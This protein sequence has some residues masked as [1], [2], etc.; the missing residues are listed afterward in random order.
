MTRP[1]IIAI[2]PDTRGWIII[3][4]RLG[5]THAGPLAEWLDAVPHWTAPSGSVAFVESIPYIPGKGQIATRVQGEIRGRAIQAVASG[6]CRVVEVKAQAWQRAIGVALPSG[7]KAPSSLSP[8]QRRK[9]LKSRIMDFCRARSMD[10][11]TADGTFPLSLH[12]ADAFAIWWYA[13]A[14][15]RFREL[16]ARRTT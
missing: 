4:D 13:R 14:D 11:A 7:R 16:A 2:D 8:A 6:G 5:V 3:G 12:S 15:L 10:L 1:L 9:L